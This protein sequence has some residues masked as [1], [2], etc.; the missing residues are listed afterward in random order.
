MTRFLPALIALVIACGLSSGVGAATQTWVQARSDVAP[1]PAI[2]FGRLANGMLYAIL[3]NDTPAHQTSIRLRIGS[4]SLEERD[5]QQGLAHFLEHMAFKG[6]THVPEGEMLRLLERRGLA[7]GPD[8]NAFTAFDETVFMLDLP[9][10]DP[11]TLNLGVMLMRETASE[12]TLSQKAMEPERGVVLS[13]ERLRATPDVEAL[14]KRLFFL[15]PGQLAPKRLPI[16]QVEVLKTA[17]VSLI[18]QYYEANYRPD[19]AQLVIV[20]DIDP[21][22]VEAKIK[23]TF[24]DWKPIGPETAEP[25]CGALAP[26]GPEAQVIVQPGAHPSLS[27]AWLK[28]FEETPE[29]EAKDRRLRIEGIATAVLNRRLERLAQGDAPPFVGA[30]AGVGDQFRSGR[31]ATISILPKPGG[32][33]A[34]LEAALRVEQQAAAFGV[35]QGEVD[36]E[37]AEARAGLQSALAGAATRKT[38]DLAQEIVSAI[39]D[40]E[41]PTSP[42]QDLGRF[43][44]DVKGLTAA[45]VSATLKA[46]F[47][48]A[49]PVLSMT[50]PDPVEGGEGAVKTAFLADLKQAPV[51]AAAVA[52]KTWPYASFG[53]PGRVVERRAVKD[54]NVTFVR[55]AN[56]VRL[57]IRP[58]ALRKDQVLVR[59]R[60]GDGRLGLPK[61]RDSVVWAMS[62]WVQ[63][64]LGKITLEDMQAVLASHLFEAEPGLDDDALLL[65]GATRP[66]DLDVQMQVL[67]AYVADPG[68]RPSGFERIRSLFQT[69]LQQ[70]DSTPGGVFARES[71]MLEHAGDRRWA[72]PTLADVTAAKPADLDALLRPRLAG[73]PL[74]VVVTGDADVETVIAAV[75]KTFAALPARAAPT[76]PSPAALDVRFPAGGGAPVRLTH[77]GRADQAVADEAWP[78]AGLFADPQRARAV[79]IAAEVLKLRLI[80]KVRIAEGST[81]SP[82]VDSSP[83][84]V[85]PSYGVVQAEVETPPAKITGF[86]KTVDDIAADLATKGPTPDELERAVKP[87]I[88]SMA[89]AQ[90]TNEYWLTWLAGADREPRRLDV[91]RTTLSGYRRLTVE[92]V[93]QAAAAFF[94]PAKAWRREVVAADAAVK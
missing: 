44:R 37:V 64:G 59:V 86:F 58:S 17:P 28:P 80:D 71:E 33:A 30:G 68:L 36:R 10:S 34:A 69:Q 51:A 70:L 40:D 82:S 73:A 24:S 93:R 89:K 74:E 78:T 91:P 16:G 76:P 27:V 60:I 42:A 11:E 31:L 48:G 22:A 14:K 62:A 75:A 72:V 6:S 19:R 2:R 83:S 15:F 81:Y 54:L 7:F 53:A 46:I 38:P 39:E 50:S 47:S 29:T 90:E 26:R 35:T 21:D 84:D 13:E 57:N 63:G 65:S 49:G 67:A 8:T 25:A 55:F 52:A 77:K 18:R 12:L 43:D 87:R 88:E 92:D 32:W 41:V 85:F 66:A 9:E 5:D 94:T 20:G 4:G 45:E 23:A 61:D 1:D 3:K 56:G 79:N